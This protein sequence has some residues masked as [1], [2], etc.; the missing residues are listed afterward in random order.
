MLCAN[1]YEG[2]TMSVENAE[3]LIRFMKDDPEL[4]EKVRT[5]GPEKFTA[6]SNAA[7]ASC[8]SYDFVCAIIR[9]I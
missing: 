9:T 4:K 1:Q 6:V 3:R 8:T 5:A 7:G 2:K